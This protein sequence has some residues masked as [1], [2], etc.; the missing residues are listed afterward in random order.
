MRKLLLLN[1]KDCRVH[2]IRLRLCVMTLCVDTFYAVGNGLGEVRNQMDAALAYRA[3]EQ[4][5][6]DLY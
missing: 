2:A 1:V 6:K 3:L 5:S 4:Y